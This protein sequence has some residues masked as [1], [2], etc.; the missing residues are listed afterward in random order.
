MN[1]ASPEEETLPVIEARRVYTINGACLEGAEREKGS[2]EPGK[3]A[4]MI[5]LDRDITST[6]PDEIL[7]ARVLTTIIGGE[8]VY[9]AEE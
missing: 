3:L 7:K 1:T 5:I 8:I 6:D 2:I 9:K 4:D